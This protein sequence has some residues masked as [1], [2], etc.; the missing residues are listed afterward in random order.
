MRVPYWTHLCFQTWTPPPAQWEG[1]RGRRGVE[2]RWTEQRGRQGINKMEDWQLSSAPLSM[3]TWSLATTETQTTTTSVPMYVC[4]PLN[5][6]HLM[7]IQV[8]QFSLAHTGSLQSAGLS[9]YSAVSNSSSHHETLS[10]LHHI[11]QR[12][13]ERLQLKPTTPRG[14]LPSPMILVA[15]DIR[16]DPDRNSKVRMVYMYCTNATFMYDCEFQYRVTFSILLPS[17]S[18]CCL[19]HH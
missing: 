2:G 11:V 19:S 6:I 15:M 9:P 17:L 13:P 4:K 12:S 8:D 1:V 7:C 10:R 16:L 18:V 5:C 3:F 14:A